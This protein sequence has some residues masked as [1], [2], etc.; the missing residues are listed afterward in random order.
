MDRKSKNDTQ[1]KKTKVMIFNFSNNYKFTTR[2]K[3]NNENLEIVNKTKLLG[4]ILTDDLKWDENT[5]YLVKKAYQRM[6]LLRKVAS[7]GAS[8]DEKRTI[9]ILYIRN[10]LEQSCVV[11]SSRL[12][13]DNIKDLERVQKAALKIILNKSFE[14]YE[15]ALQKANLETLKKRRENLCLKFSKKCLQNEKTD[16]LFPL[17]KKQHIMVKRIEKNIK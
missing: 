17:S 3:L 7:F 6:Q 2:L 14:N 10:I 12:T 11:W 1:S 15:L 13:A 8:L 5:T 9:Y 4:L 16:K